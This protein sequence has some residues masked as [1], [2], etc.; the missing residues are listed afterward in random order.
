VVDSAGLK[1]EGDN[2][3]E[4]PKPTS[5]ALGYIV[6]TIITLPL[7]LVLTIATGRR[8]GQMPLWPQFICFVVFFG[9]ANAI[10]RGRKYQAG[11]GQQADI[12]IQRD[13]HAPSLSQS[14]HLS[15]FGRVGRLV[16]GKLVITES[17]M[18]AIQTN[19]DAFDNVLTLVTTEGDGG[20][21]TRHIWHLVLQQNKGITFCT[22]LNQAWRFTSDNVTISEKE[23]SIQLDDGLR[24]SFPFDT[25]NSDN[26]VCLRAWRSKSFQ[27]YKN[28]DSLGGWGLF[29]WIL[30][31]KKD[32][33]AWLPWELPYQKVADGVATLLAD[34]VN[35]PTF[36]RTLVYHLDEERVWKVVENL[37]AMPA[38]G[39]RQLLRQLLDS[40]RTTYQPEWGWPFV[41]LVL[42]LVTI[43]IILFLC[44]QWGDRPQTVPFG[45][46]ANDMVYLGIAGFCAAVVGLPSFIMFS[47]ALSRRSH[48]RRIAEIE[49]ALRLK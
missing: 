26:A 21:K 25:H 3:T 17:E 13:E 19:P 34:K 24:E 38:D 35:C 28:G 18:Q 16:D 15:M 39:S 41:L 20:M 7:M 40:M 1:I 46:G 2:K 12:L 44:A 6:A 48:L 30:V 33:G 9:I 42:P 37:Q 5:K 29:A 14:G 23:V 49:M 47:R 32:P 43:P 11:H 10:N 36:I 4:P 45:R 27:E 8:T 31:T 22:S